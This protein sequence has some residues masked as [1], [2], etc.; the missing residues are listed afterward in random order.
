MN[1]TK[2]E[3]ILNIVKIANSLSEDEVRDIKNYIFWVIVS[4]TKEKKRGQQMK[5]LQIRNKTLTSIEVAEMVGKEHHK[6]LRDI[7]TY[8]E[9]LGKSNFGYTDFFIESNYESSQNK[10]LPCYLIT[11]KGCEFIANKLS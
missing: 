8:I 11:K 2:A 4:K 1:T 10:K 6:L 3:N 9:Q 7:K 5:A